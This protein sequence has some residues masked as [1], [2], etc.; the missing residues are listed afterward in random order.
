MKKVGSFLLSIFPAGVMVWI[1]I[2]ISMMFGAAISL[3]CMIGAGRMGGLDTALYMEAA[4]RAYSEGMIYILMAA[5]IFTVLVFAVWR[6]IE[7]R[8]GAGA[9]L[10]GLKK[11]K[12]WLCMLAFCVSA[13]CIT[14]LYLQGVSVLFPAQLE[15]YEENMEL[16]LPEIGGFATFL[17]TIV[18]APISEELVF[19]GV[20]LYYA[21]K[22]CSRFFLANLLQ[23]ALFGLV[24]MNV[25]QGIYA[26]MLGLILG[27][28]CHTFHSVWL[29]MAAHAV[30]NFLGS[31][32]GGLMDYLP[33]GIITYI[34]AAVLAVI[35][36]YYGFSSAKSSR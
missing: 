30:F 21:G 18:L 23:A 36:L 10:K 12:P 6:R 24:H 9:G 25:I 33:M 35:L 19:R 29:S 22:L 31:G 16:L 34:G 3:G 8:D 17:S 4:E 27:Y 26:F 20:T 1:Q 28:I 15:A 32:A 13:Y 14:M 2:A 5:Q 7:C 11:R